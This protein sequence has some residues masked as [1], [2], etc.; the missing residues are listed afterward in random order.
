MLSTRPECRYRQILGTRIEATSYE[1]AT[2]LITAWAQTGESRYVCIT[3]VH[4]VIEA[5]RSS[6]LQCI[7]NE[8][9]LNTPDGMPLVWALRR[10]GIE[11]ATRVYGP[12]LT[13]H[14]CRAAAQTGL[15][16][17]LYGGTPESLSDFR[18]FLEHRFP[19]LKVVCCISPPFRPLTE[20]EDE[21]Y[22]RQITASGARIL[23][24]GIG[25]PKQEQWMHAHK[26]RIHAVMVGVGAAFDFHAG[27]VRQAPSWIQQSGFEWLF[28]LAVEPHRLWRRY[29]RIVPSFIA[30]F[31]KQLLQ[32]RL[33]RITS[34]F[35]LTIKE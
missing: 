17:G 1:E 7:W 23:L 16:I 13:L 24:V 8:A 30:S 19:S 25:C 15:P 28:R 33:G 31:G 5:Q 6:R 3:S 21:Q 29:A 4:G 2:E 10:L 18:A 34:S 14:L 20:E 26:G 11:T 22:T 12:D 35:H 32:H 9:D 27:R